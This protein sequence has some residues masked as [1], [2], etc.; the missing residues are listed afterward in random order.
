MMAAY[1]VRIIARAV[2]IRY[3]G[4]ETDV[5]AILDSYNLSEE[6]RTLVLAQITT[7]N[8]DIPVEGVAA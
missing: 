8:P 2:A 5:T 7:S 3:S 6:D 4:G 1:K